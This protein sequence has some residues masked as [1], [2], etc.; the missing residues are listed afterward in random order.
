MLSDFLTN[1][2]PNFIQNTDIVITLGSTSAENK[3]LA[4]AQPFKITLKVSFQTV[5]YNQLWLTLV[6]C[7]LYYTTFKR[8]V[9][10]VRRNRASK[11]NH[12]RK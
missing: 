7:I 4:S 6:T 9:R 8:L 2:A 3:E 1:R 5:F 11:R 12:F 10:L